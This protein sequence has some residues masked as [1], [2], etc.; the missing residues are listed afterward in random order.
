MAL[1]REQYQ[2]IQLMYESIRSHNRRVLDKRIEEIYHTIPKY[3]EIQQLIVST[4]MQRSKD[5]IIGTSEHTNNLHQD[6]ENLRNKKE[7]LLLMNGYPIDYLQPIYKCKEC[8][9][10]GYIDN[11]KCFCFKQKEIALLYSQSLIVSLFDTNNFRTL[12]ESYYAEEDLPNFRH[13]VS[14]SKKF[15]KNFLKSYQNILFYGRVGTGKSFLS[16]CIAKE[17]WVQNYSLLYFDAVGFFKLLSNYHFNYETKKEYEAFYTDICTCD[18]LILD[19]LGTEVTNP[20]IVSQLFACINER[21]IKKLPTIIS[22]NYSLKEIQ[23]TY[24]ERISSRITSAYELCKL[25][26]NDIRILQKQQLIRK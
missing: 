3:E 24:S 8:S 10:T 5:L 4:S 26:G 25:S 2:S 11:Q 22:T 17:L 14:I 15:V 1:N 16:C 23:E 9:D 19:D 7:E 20:F 6:L 13:A 21:H 12:S 18:L